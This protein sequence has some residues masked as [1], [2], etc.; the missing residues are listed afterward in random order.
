MISGPGSLVLLRHGQSSSNA[1][2]AFTG[3]LDS[4]LTALGRRQ[5]VEAG[6][7]MAAV[8]V[9]P[10]VV[11][12]SLLSRAIASADIA[13]A[14]T[15][16]CW[17]PVRRSWR[18]NERHYGALTGRSK[19]AVRTEVGEQRYRQWRNSLYVAPPPMR[20]SALQQLRRDPRYAVLPGE[21]VPASESLG[22][23]LARLLP[24]WFDVLVPEL[25]AGWTVLV[26]AHGNSLRALV[27]H[28]DRLS[29]PELTAL[30]IPT[31]APLLYR[32]AESPRPNRRGGEPLPGHPATAWGMTRSFI[33]LPNGH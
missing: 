33:V 15:D 21:L 23:V 24:Y 5:S 18:L 14:E 9:R 27:C 22:D 11:H 13:L 1:A 8:G 16:R 10:D 7:R 25:A 26:A 31:G 3:W 32:L 17:I 19:E 4:P 29:Q 20:E 2:R 28:L 30:R 6:R 12:T